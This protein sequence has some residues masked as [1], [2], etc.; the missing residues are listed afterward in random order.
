MLKGDSGSFILDSSQSPPAIDFH[1]WRG[2]VFGIYKLD[3]ESLALCVT[4]EVAPR[5]DRLSTSPNDERIL[6]RYKKVR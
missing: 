6:S 5:P 4:R 2:A 1:Q 3:G